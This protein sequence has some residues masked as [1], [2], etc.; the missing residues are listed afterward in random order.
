M[1]LREYWNII[2]RRW[3]LPVGIALV[4]L[5]ASTAV[6][7][8]GA[9]AFKTGMRIAVS[10]VP[11]LDPS[12]T[13]Y[14]DPT[15]Y[16]NLDSEYL[17]DDMSEF[18]TSRAFATEVQRELATGANYNTDLASIVD[19]TRTK[20]THRFIDVTITTPTLEE[21]QAIAGSIS[22]IIND[23]AHLAQY[24][25]ALAAENTYLTV[26][27]PPDT[28]RANT[29][30]GLVS[31]VGL[32]TVIGLLLGVA[33]AFLLHYLDTRLR[34]REEAESALQLPVLAEIPRPAN[35][36]GAAA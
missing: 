10:T 33:L 32:R 11:T 36:R 27:T 1:E 21:G 26:V 14:F 12:T 8:R 28:H 6:G 3:W 13:P 18:M 29:A 20:K 17:A 5:V 2:R 22:R 15:Y 25:R 16:S 7:L 30:L 35:R 31:E 24:L 19:A 4:A 23:R 9:A 34:T